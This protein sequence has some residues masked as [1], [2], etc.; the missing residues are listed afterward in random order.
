MKVERTLCTIV[1]V[2]EAGSYLLAPMSRVVEARECHK[3]SAFATFCAIKQ[4]QDEP[5]SSLVA[6]TL[7][8]VLNLLPIWSEHRSCPHCLSLSGVGGEAAGK[9]VHE[10]D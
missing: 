9:V 1:S 7:L 10:G 6:H 5:S 8:S 2:V 3:L 4:G